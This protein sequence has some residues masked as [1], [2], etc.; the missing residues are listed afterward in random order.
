MRAA[1][2]MI[3]DVKAASPEMTVGEA[4]AMM[5]ATGHG[6]LPVVD[7]QGLVIG[8]MSGFNLVKRCLPNYLEEVG[9]LY[10]SQEFQPFIVRV[11]E[12]SRM[13]VREMMDTEFPTVSADTPLAE[14]ASR[15]VMHRVR[16]IPVVEDSRLLGVVGIQDLLTSIASLANS[17][18]GGP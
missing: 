14:I 1:D 7:A 8:L 11:K 18:E 5:K 4:A 17:P 16:L 12:T 3:R 6:N 2:I 13:L 9:D 10:R 15:M